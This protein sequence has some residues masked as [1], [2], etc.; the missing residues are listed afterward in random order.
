[1]TAFHVH[2]FKNSC[3]ER[4][5]FWRQNVTG[6]LGDG[7]YQYYFSLFTVTSSKRSYFLLHVSIIDFLLIKV[8]DDYL[9]DKGEVNF[10]AE[11]LTSVRQL[12][13]HLL[14]L[15]SETHVNSPDEGEL[16]RLARLAS[17]QA[18]LV[19]RLLKKL[20]PT[21]E[22]SKTVEFTRLT[23]QKERLS[24]SFEILNLLQLKGVA[25]NKDNDQEKWINDSLSQCC[26]HNF[27]YFVNKEFFQGWG[28]GGK[29]VLWR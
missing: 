22:F 27:Y 19:T 16:Q 15:I 20:P 17:E 21:P 29:F 10:W 13:K 23:I 8:E 24:V 5:W 18:R 26:L 11:K 14:L 3:T 1:M 7:L 4:V 25:C 9:F 28:G 2:C 12:S 6:I